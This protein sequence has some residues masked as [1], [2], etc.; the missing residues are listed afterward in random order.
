MK[1]KEQLSLMF[2]ELD[3][4][5][6]EA[7]RFLSLLQVGFREVITEVEINET[8]TKE[9]ASMEL[10]YTGVVFAL[11]QVSRFID[12]VF[13]TELFIDNKPLV[14][15]Q[16]TE[17]IGRGSLVF[18]SFLWA[19]ELAK[20][21]D[22]ENEEIFTQ[23]QGSE[24]KLRDAQ[25]RLEVWKQEQEQKR[26]QRQ[27]SKM[28]QNKAQE[29]IQSREHERRQD[30]SEARVLHSISVSVLA[31]ELDHRLCNEDCSGTAL[32]G[33]NN[34][35]VEADLGQDADSCKVHCATQNNCSQA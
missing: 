3:D 34:W 18:Q 1:P 15:K 29:K 7:E 10:E 11:E 19:G 8:E 6:E 28:E 33:C 27:R 12:G 13:G 17:G 16:E 26:I 23:F 24:N 25:E 2:E 20:I 32:I 14:S 31:S 22:A 5:E 35:I 9:E 21:E 4:M 30:Q